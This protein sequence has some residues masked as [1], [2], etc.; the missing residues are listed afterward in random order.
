MPEQ[1]T[2][3]VNGERHPWQPGLQMAQLLE[4]LGTPPG[5]VATALNGHF[6][7]RERRAHT[8]L[9]PG[10]VLTVFQPIVGG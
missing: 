2:I 9:Q 5:S 1:P 4:G 7:P 6:V 10:D 8:L 3:E